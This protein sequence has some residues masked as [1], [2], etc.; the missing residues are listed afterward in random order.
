[1]H[2]G[3]KF[4]ANSSSYIHPVPELGRGW[5]LALL[6]RTKPL[7]H[8]SL[9]LSALFMYST[10]LN[11]GRVKCIQGYWGEMKR[12]HTL[13]LRELRGHIA[14]LS[15]GDSTTLKQTIEAVACVIQLI[16]FEVTPI[17][18]FNIIATDYLKTASSWWYR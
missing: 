4:N 8:T 11:T 2:N 13:A 18:H 1:M 12:H 14:G 3:C 6:T 17:R 7:Y 10:L 16:S 9:A 5:L 15:N